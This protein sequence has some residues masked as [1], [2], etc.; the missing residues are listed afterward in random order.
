VSEILLQRAGDVSNRFI[1]V[2]RR[3]PEAPML[4]LFA[5]ATSGEAQHYATRWRDWCKFET[6]VILR[7]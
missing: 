7:Y 1:V 2:Y 5:A 3:K 6:F 4:F